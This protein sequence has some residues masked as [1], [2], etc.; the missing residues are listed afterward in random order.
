[1]TISARVA[2]AVLLGSLLS[3][4]VLA[5]DLSGAGSTFVAPIMSRWSADYA[6]KTGTVVRYQSIGSGGGITEIRSGNV[7]FGASDAPLK[8]S[9]T[10]R[11]G[12][13]QFPLVMGGIV[14]VLNLEGIKPGEIKFNGALLADIFLG[15]VKKW[16][17][18][19]IV[20]LNPAQNLPAT[21]IRVVHRIDGSG[22]TFNWTNYLS[23]V[24]PTWQA[25]VGAGIAVDWPI[26][27][28]GKGNEGVTALVQQTANAIGYVEYAYV[29]KNKLTY[30]LVQNKAGKFV[31]PG[32]ASFQAAAA[33]ANWTRAGDFDL[34]ITDASGEDAHPIAAT[35]F[36]LMQ[37]ASKDAA[38]RK[39]SLEFFDWALNS[40]QQQ[41]SE[42]DYVALPP[43]LVGQIEA[44][45]KAAFA[46][47]N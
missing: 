28:G 5:L 30:G 4:P 34:V 40:G 33:G 11:A 29:L 32:V 27:A 18:P 21:A 3:D 46:T 12:L 7:D 16:N 41:A 23:K 15:K 8:P 44:Y 38:R 26:G 39:A 24:S 10:Q 9:D 45:W 22:T 17:D 31:Q 43:N 37:R 20:A 6:A 47:V 13:V 2:A 1:M 19:A 14:P 25:K 36:V 35:S 42:L